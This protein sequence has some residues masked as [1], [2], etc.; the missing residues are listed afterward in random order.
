MKTLQPFWKK[1]GE[2]NYVAGKIK[3]GNQT[4]CKIEGKWVS[5]SITKL[6]SYWYWYVTFDDN[7]T[8]SYIYYVFQDG[9]IIIED[10]KSSN[11]SVRTCIKAWQYNFFSTVPCVILKLLHC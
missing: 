4:L 11:L 10:L 7:E 3:M 1:S 5:T 9:E 2:S 6:R 8:E